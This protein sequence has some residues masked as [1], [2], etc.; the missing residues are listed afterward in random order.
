MWIYNNWSLDLGPWVFLSVFIVEVLNVYCHL[1]SKGKDL[2]KL[3]VGRFLSPLARVVFT[4]ILFSFALSI[5][6]APD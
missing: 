4:A 3:G 5:C 6:R 1:Y 2:F